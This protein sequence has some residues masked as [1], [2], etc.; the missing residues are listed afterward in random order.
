MSFLR[1]SL[2]LLSFLILSNVLKEFSIDGAVH[3]GNIVYIG[4]PIR[5][6]RRVSSNN[7]QHVDKTSGSNYRSKKKINFDIN[8]KSSFSSVYSSSNGDRNTDFINKKQRNGEMITK[9]ICV[10]KSNNHMI[11]LAEKCKESVASISG[12]V[13]QIGGDRIDSFLIQQN[14]F[15]TALSYI[16]D[17]N[18]PIHSPQ[19]QQ[20]QRRQQRQQ[21]IRHPSATRLL[22]TLT[23][24]L[25]SSC[26][27]IVQA[28]GDKVIGSGT[29]V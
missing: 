21:L 29:Q 9:D 23:F 7:D 8:N 11:Y 3:N 2:A 12:K 22:H 15:S 28:F 6:T 26:S 18:F 10:I 1:R 19:Q 24:H 27:T 14:R 16:R 25:S 5:H 20:Q 4:S 17:S 13:Q